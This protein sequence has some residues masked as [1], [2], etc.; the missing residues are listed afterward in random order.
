MNWNSCSCSGRLNI[1]VTHG[2]QMTKWSQIELVRAITPTFMHG[3]QNNLPY[4]IIRNI[5]SSK[6]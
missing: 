3:F 4:L 1:K 5:C 2:G 6:L